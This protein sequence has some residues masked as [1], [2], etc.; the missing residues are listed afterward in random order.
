MIILYVGKEIIFKLCYPLYT[1]LARKR[2]SC[3]GDY[4]GSFVISYLHWCPM[5]ERVSLITAPS[6][7]RLWIYKAFTNQKVLCVRIWN[8][9]LITCQAAVC[10]SGKTDAFSSEP[11][12]RVFIVIVWLDT[13]KFPFLVK[14]CVLN[15]FEFETFT[16]LFCW[17]EEFKKQ[18]P[19]LSSL[20]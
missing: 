19:S 5:S 7:C 3:T 8:S 16:L 17:K 15:N 11:Q 18:L 13:Y 9:W 20:K 4:C 14:G 1:Q 10:F 6:E 2:W 12:R